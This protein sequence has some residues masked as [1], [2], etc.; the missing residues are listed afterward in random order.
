[1]TENEEMIQFELPDFSEITATG[2]RMLLEKTVKHNGIWRIH[3]NDP[4]DIFPSD[5][6][7]DR[8]DAPEKLNLYN[9]EVY[10][11]TTKKYIYTLPNK[12]IKYIYNQ[13]MSCKEDI[14]KNK[15]TANKALITYL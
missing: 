13:I 14:I 6:H 12:A 15:I 8:Q 11:K 3:K 4:D 9:G 2:Q 5:P 10:N 7:A 1:M